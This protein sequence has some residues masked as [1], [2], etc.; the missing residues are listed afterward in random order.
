MITSEIAIEAMLEK[1]EEMKT[2]DNSGHF[3]IWRNT[4]IGTLKRI[5]PQNITIINQLDSLR[6][7]AP[8]GNGDYTSSAKKG[9]KILLESLIGDLKKFG[10]EEIRNLTNDKPSLNVNVNQHNNQTQ[11][12][13]VTINIDFL[14]EILKGELR[15]SEIDEVKEILESEDEPK[16][17]KRKFIDK[18][19]SFGSDVATNILANILTNPAIY[20]QM[21]RML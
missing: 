13:S 7:S 9:A 10:I 3:N 2:V 1:L 20:E 17:I 6:A 12:T 14:I 5:V 8:I 21:G 11:S 16:E 18:I 19:K 4:T 15:T